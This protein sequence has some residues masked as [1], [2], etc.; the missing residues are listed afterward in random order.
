MKQNKFIIILL[1]AFV[2]FMV[3]IIWKDYWP[4]GNTD[5]ERKLD[6]EIFDV[7][8]DRGDSV[9]KRTTDL[10]KKKIV[11][12]AE[13]ARKVENT[14]NFFAE[15]VKKDPGAERDKLE[16][17]P[18]GVEAT[19]VEEKSKVVI[20]YRERP[21]Q[22][23]QRADSV[24][25]NPMPKEK[26]FLT[27][28]LFKGN[29]GTESK[30]GKD[31]IGSSISATAVIQYD[32]KVINGSDVTIRLTQE[33]VL[34]N[35]TIEKNSFLSGRITFGDQRA[36]IVVTNIV[37]A[38]QSFPVLLRAY[39]AADGV[40]GIA[41]PGATNQQISNDVLNATVQEATRKINAPLLNRSTASAG[42][43]KVNEQSVIVP[44]GY[45]LILKNVKG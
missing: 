33:L 34:P 1:P 3:Y 8:V 6:D 29:V 22:K 20:V 40:E 4:K 37:K 31:A 15:E 39:A 24:S 41:I 27:G 30:D 19:K 10:Y 44:A 45:E 26:C 5:S 28:D 2:L 21:A 36:T 38:N 25:I 11:K 16:L 42:N 32:Q 12:K 13:L 18:Q 17:A 9:P 14:D 23:K 43:R 7:A 35:V